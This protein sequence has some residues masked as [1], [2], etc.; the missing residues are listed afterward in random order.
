MRKFSISTVEEQ[1][2]HLDRC[3]VT[4]AIPAAAVRISQPKMLQQSAAL[5]PQ[6]TTEMCT[7]ESPDAPEEAG[8]AFS[9]KEAKSST[10]PL[11]WHWHEICSRFV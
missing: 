5:K 3:Q 10:A 11:L 8:A 4:E 2:P 9:E 1:A 6:N 7:G